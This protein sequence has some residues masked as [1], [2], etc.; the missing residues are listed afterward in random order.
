[1]TKPSNSLSSLQLHAFSLT[2]VY[3]SSL[4]K[5]PIQAGAGYPL[6]VREVSAI[7]HL[8]GLNFRM[9]LQAPG[10]GMFSR[11]GCKVLLL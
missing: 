5:P 4:P 2:C 9:V 11:W 10:Q 1:M 7:W 6:E 3:L 8:M